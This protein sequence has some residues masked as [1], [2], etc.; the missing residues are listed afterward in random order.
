LKR[1]SSLE[2]RIVSQNR[3]TY[4]T[5]RI[6]II[7]KKTDTEEI[8]SEIQ[9]GIDEVKKT[10]DRLKQREKQI[11]KDAQQTEMEVQQFQLQKQA[12]LN[13]ISVA[14]PLKISQLFMFEKSGL[15]TGPTDT[16]PVVANG[17]N[18]NATAALLAL[19]DDREG[20]SDS[21]HESRKVSDGLSTADDRRLVTEIDM[22]SHVLFTN[23]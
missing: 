4:L 16:K 22:K 11:A 19:V 9:K 20:D 7:E 17:N 21:G 12:A 2:V 8:T 15:Y 18:N 23:Q 1:F 3:N 10:L 14:V 6:A 5:F 13:Q